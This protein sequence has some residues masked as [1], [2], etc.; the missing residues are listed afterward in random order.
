M[1]QRLASIDILRGLTIILMII[2][3]SPGTWEHVAAPLCHSAWNG[4]TLADT[5]FPC[6]MFIM[7]MTTYISLRKY[8][9][10]LSSALIVKI[11][12]RTFVLY[13][14]GLLVNWTAAGFPGL[15][16]L[17]VMGVLQRFAITYLVVSIIGVTVPLRRIP[18]IAVFLLVSYAV[19]LLAF[20]GYAY[21]Q[22]NLLSL[23]DRAC[24]GSNMMNDGGI[25]PEGILSTIPSIAHVMIGYC[26]GA[27]ALSDISLKDKL[28]RMTQWGIAMLFIGLLADSFLPINKKIWSPTFVLATCGLSLLAL[29]LL[30]ILIDVKNARMP[31]KLFLVFGMNPL[32]CYVLGELMY[33]AFYLLH[34][35]G[36]SFQNYF[37]WAF[38]SLIGDN[39]LAS[40]I[41][42]LAL[43]AIIGIAGLVLYTKRIFVKI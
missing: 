27:V 41:S 2:V 16:D 21:N 25:D 24:L 30:A 5:I 8:D 15:H 9:F 34:I 38:A 3:N 28:L 12:R 19:L 6:F 23:I 29:V 39:M 17:R 32:V 11:L 13:L 33:A 10:N 42:A 37:Y 7:G 1:K 14:L 31:Q 4:L 26:V 35:Y 22:S 20:N 40:F 18:H 36:T 43:S